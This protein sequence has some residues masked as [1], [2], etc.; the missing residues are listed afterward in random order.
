MIDEW[1][2]QD[3]ER[4]QSL[5]SSVV[6]APESEMDREVFLEGVS[7]HIFRQGRPVFSFNWDSGGPGAGAGG[8]TIY[9]WRDTYFGLSGDF[10]GP[11]GPF[12]TLDEALEGLVEMRQPGKIYVNGATVEIRCELWSDEELIGRLAVA[13][14][15]TPEKLKVNGRVWSGH[16]L[17]AEAERLA[18]AG[19]SEDDGES[20]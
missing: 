2:K 12:D 14:D 1:P 4:F 11:A 7:N 6:P 10:Y 9:E 18:G 15:S 5:F 19:S 20:A 8:E 17:A 3:L 13:P 16:N